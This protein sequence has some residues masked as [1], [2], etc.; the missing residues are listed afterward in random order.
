MLRITILAD[1]VSPTLR[2]EGKLVGP[3]VREAETCWRRV[4]ED[5]MGAVLHLDLTGVTMIDADGKALLARAHAHGATFSACGCMMRA[6]IAEV[7][8][9][10]F[11]PG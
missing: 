8:S 5:R 2:L 7:T 1:A 6:I 11:L 9:G 10:S 4:L 3:W